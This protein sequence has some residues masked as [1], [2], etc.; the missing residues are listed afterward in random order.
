MRVTTAG[1]NLI[2]L[3]WFPRVFPV[4]VYLVREDDGFTLVDTAIPGVARS[5]LGAAKDHGAPIRRIALT[6]AHSDHVGSLDALRAA[7]PET[8]V[9]ISARDARFLRGDKSLDP[10]EPQTKLKGG[11][12]RRMTTPTTELGDGDAVGSLRVVAAPGHTPGQVAFFDDRDGSL[13][14]GDAFQTQG[15]IAVAGVV[16]PL[17]PIPGLLCWH[18]PTAVE[19]AERLRALE[20]RRLAVGHGPMLEEPGTKM[21]EAIAAGKTKAQAA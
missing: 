2:Q 20:P 3:T 14:V 21:D 5:I 19:S 12:P 11:F 10:G 16:R 18:L 4:S 6:H 8:E 1:A 15:G 13:I 9:V 7:L 17:F